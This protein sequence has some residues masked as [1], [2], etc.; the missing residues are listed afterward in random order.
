MSDAKRH[1][2]LPN[3]ITSYEGGGYDGCIWELNFCFVDAD[4]KFHDIYSSGSMGCSTAEDI[5]DE[6]R[7]RQGDF[8]TY[9]ATSEEDMRRLSAREPIHAVL[10]L[11]IWFAG[12]GYDSIRLYPTCDDCGHPFDAMEGL[13]T[14][15]HG[16]GGIAT[17]F[18]HII[19]NECHLKRDAEE[20]EW[21]QQHGESHDGQGTD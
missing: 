19:C 8:D 15:E 4:G 17:S 1:P 10:G 13:G 11:A 18:R 2:L 9:D 12:E 21:N 3:T 5:Q 14:E 16:I 7:R 6:F 20:E